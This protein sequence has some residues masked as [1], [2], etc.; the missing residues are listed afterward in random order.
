NVEE[1]D[2]NAARPEAFARVGIDA[3]D[4][5]VAALRQAAEAAGLE[6]PSISGGLFWRYPLTSPEQAVREKSLR[7]AVRMLEI[8]KLLGAKVAL[9]VPGVVTADVS[10]QQAYDRALGAMRELAPVA[11]KLGVTIGVENVW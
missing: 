5:E 4:A 7:T 2:P 6:L 11:E 1:A 10:Y 8:A 3:P 9:V